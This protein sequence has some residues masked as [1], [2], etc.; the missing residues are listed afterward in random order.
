MALTYF[1]D[2]LDAGSFDIEVSTGQLLTKSPLDYESKNSYQLRVL[3]H[4]GRSETAIAVTV[5]VTNVDEA[6]RAFFLASPPRVG[7]VSRV[8]VS[9]PDGQVLVQSFSWQISEDNGFTWSPVYASGRNYWIP[10]SEY[11]G[12]LMRTRL[13]YSD[14]EGDNKQAVATAGSVIAAA[15]QAPQIAVS[16][17]VSG[18]SIPWGLAFTP[19]GTMLFT[20]RAG[21]LSAR[22]TDGTVK[23]INADFSD[24]Y[25]EQNTGLMAIVV[26]PDF[27]SN[28]KFYTCQGHPG[29]GG[30]K[31]SS[32]IHSRLDYR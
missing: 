15:E 19:D 7:H 24:L 5:A 28:R 23:T 31:N 21:I 27:A 14:G 6:G 13:E 17:F 26:D 1:L 30:A 3:A 29:D 2:G 8:Q 20:Q 32:I 22:L 12:A 11:E 4:D 18:I 10:Y 9:D 16:T 25:V